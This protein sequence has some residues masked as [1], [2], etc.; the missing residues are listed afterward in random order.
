[1]TRRPIAA[2]LSLLLILATPAHTQI[3]S[4]GETIEVAIVNVDVVVTDAKGERVHG[5]TREDFEILEDGKPQPLSHFAEYRGAARGGTAGVEIQPVERPPDQPSQRRTLVIFLEKFKLS[6]LYVDPFIASVKDMVRKS[7]RSGDSVSI[8]TFDHAARVRLPSTGDI[9][10]ADRVLDEIGRECVGPVREKT[11]MAAVEANEIRAFDQ[12]GAEM[13]AAHGIIASRPT[14]N[15]VAVHAARIFAVEARLEMNRRVAAINSALLGMAGIEGKKMLLLAS[16]RLGEYIGAEYYYAAGVSESVLPPQERSEL[17][18]RAAVRGIIANANAAGVTIYPVFPT[19]LDYAPSDPDTPNVTR[20]VLMNEM[21]MLREIADK[22]GGVTSYGTMNTAELMP[23]IADDMS[24][25]YSLAYRASSRRDDQARKIVV[26]TRDRDL[27]VR[28][29]REFVEKSEDTRMRDR[30]LA[31]LHESALE[32][33]IRL[34]AEIGQTTKA[35][36]RSR[37]APLKVR[38]PIGSLTLL[39]QGA[40]HSGAFT[41]YA[42][43][44][45]AFGEVSDVTRRTQ[46]FDIPVSD[47]QRANAGH[48]TYNLDVIV[49]EHTKQVAVGVLDE[50]SKSFGLVSVPVV[51]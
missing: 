30:V 20:Q 22:T 36:R 16:H 5:L 4:L 3:P 23:R 38:I 8:I 7:I 6:N 25:Y 21:V 49:N 41:I 50:V 29:R 1:V 34:G 32:S 42:I 26:K 40:K 24:D 11:K 39:P 51:Q 27:Q 43:T 47:L 37:T 35:G 15:E 46:A 19:G 18:N 12:E 44:G 10:K 45:G 17:D 13:L 48:F 28:A 9:A 31:A 33:D 14:G 2:V